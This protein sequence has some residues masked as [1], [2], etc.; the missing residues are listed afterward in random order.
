MG[1]PGVNMQVRRDAGPLQGQVQDDAV[2]GTADDIVPAMGEKH[3][4]RPG[5]NMQ[6]GSKLIAV[7]GLEVAR[8]DHD[9]KVRPA[10]GLI[11]VID[12]FVSAFAEARR[13]RYGEMAACGKADNAD[14]VLSD[15]PIFGFAPYQPHGAL[16]VLQRTPGRLT[17]WFSGA[18]RH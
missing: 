5:W 2:L 15:A 11:D 7:L 10:A 1:G 6:T 17:L 18:A 9:G 14:S 13:R 16:G 12:G 3:W 4:R 8:I